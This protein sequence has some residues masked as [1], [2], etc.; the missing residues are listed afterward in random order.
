MKTLITVLLGALGGFFVHAVAMKIN[1]KQT[2]IEDKKR[3]YASIVGQWLKMRNLIYDNRPDPHA[4]ADFDHMYIECINIAAGVRLVIEQSDLFDR[5]V[6]LSQLIY[7]THWSNL[8]Q[9]RF[10]ELIEMFFNRKVL[11]IINLM[12]LD[13]RDTSRLELSDLIH[14]FKGLV[15]IRRN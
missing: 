2:V 3:L 14:I 5:I 1:F 4:N 6:N 11:E 15:P 9:D 12:R 13:I 10:D 7:N 8:T